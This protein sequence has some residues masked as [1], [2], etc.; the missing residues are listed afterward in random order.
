MPRIMI[1]AAACLKVCDFSDTERG[2]CWD[3]DAAARAREGCP[4]LSAGSGRVDG[5]RA[6]RDAERGEA[7]GQGKRKETEARAGG[8]DRGGREKNEKG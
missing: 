2:E 4:E 3:Q 7:R 5:E 1:K 6:E 8:E